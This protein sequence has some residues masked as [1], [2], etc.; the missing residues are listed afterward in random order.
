MFDGGRLVHKQYHVVSR[1][2]NQA[3]NEVVKNPT[4]VANPVNTEVSF[5]LSPCL[6]SLFKPC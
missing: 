3:N 5:D 4:Q 2:L 1:N 6:D